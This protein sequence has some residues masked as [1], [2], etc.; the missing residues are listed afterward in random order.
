MEMSL[1]SMKRCKIKP[2]AWHLWSFFIEPH[3]LWNS[4]LGFVVSLEG[5]VQNICCC[6]FFFY[7]FY[8]WSTIFPARKQQIFWTT[9][10]PNHFITLYDK[11]EVLRDF[12]NTYFHWLPLLY[13]FLKR[14]RKINFCS[15]F[16]KSFR[17]VASS[18]HGVSTICLI[19]SCTQFAFYMILI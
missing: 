2:F 1:F 17:M 15:C 18:A 6:L 3:Q 7:S 12:F 4:A 10:G 5:N 8:I 14:F 19:L 11:Q 9:K 13:F 16:I